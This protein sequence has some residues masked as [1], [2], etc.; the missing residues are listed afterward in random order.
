MATVPVLPSFEEQ[1]RHASALMIAIDIYPKMMKEMLYNKYKSPSSVIVVYQL[2][3]NVID[4]ENDPLVKQL[5]A[6]EKSIVKSINMDGFAKCDI[7]LLYRLIRYFKLLPAPSRGWGAKPSIKEIREG[8]DVER[9]KRYRNDLVHRPKG[10]LSESE[11]TDIF[12][13]SINIAKRLDS[14]SP[15]HDF[16][17]K[18][19]ATKYVTQEKYVTA[20]EQCAENRGLL[21]QAQVNLLYGQDIVIKLGH[22][23][24]NNSSGTNSTRY[25]I[26]TR[27]ANMDVPA[28]IKRLDEIK[29]K[30]NDGSSEVKLLGGEIGSL[31]LDITI[32]NASFSTKKIL[33]DVLDLFLQQLFLHADIHQTPGKV[34][35]A[36]LTEN[37]ND[38]FSSGSDQGEYDFL[39]EKRSSVLKLDVDI[40]N[41]AFRDKNVLHEEISRFIDDVTGARDDDDATM[42]NGSPRDVMI[43][44]TQEKQV[45]TIDCKIVDLGHKRTYNTCQFYIRSI[46]RHWKYLKENLDV[47][48]ISN[49]LSMSKFIKC[50][51]FEHV[52]ENPRREQ[53]ENILD[54]VIRTIQ[55]SED[56]RTFLRIVENHQKDV[57]D[58]IREPFIYTE[59]ENPTSCKDAKKDEQRILLNKEML[60]ME[61]T[62]T[63]VD[64]ILDDFMEADVFDV[65]DLDDIKRPGKS[66]KTSVFIERLLQKMQKNAYL[67]L[68]KTLERIKDPSICRRILGDLEATP[69]LPHETEDGKITDLRIPNTMIVRSHRS[70]LIDEIDPLLMIDECVQKNIY[71]D[72]EGLERITDRK[73][74]ARKFLDDLQEHDKCTS[75]EK[76]LLNVFETKAMHCLSKKLAFSQ[77][78]LN[79]KDTE[80]LRQNIVRYRKEIAESVDIDE[81]KDMFIDRNIFKESLFQAIAERY[82]DKRQKRVISLLT[83]ILPAGWY[84]WITLIDVL[85][86][87]TFS[88]LAHTL[89]NKGEDNQ[90]LAKS[91]PLMFQ[92]DTSDRIEDAETSS[93]SDKK[94]K[95]EDADKSYK[96][97]ESRIQELILNVETKRLEVETARLNIERRKLE[98]KERQFAE[99]ARDSS[100][101]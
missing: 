42:Q 92:K 87:R 79:Y 58:K 31:I 89:L 71:I 81:M 24:E 61:L 54:K 60:E 34:L 93:T 20:L 18:V 26:Y 48:S 44:S 27:D 76:D 10:G 36:V 47:V 68:Q 53:A 30:L 96:S 46:T 4:D 91:I 75:L 8:D 15:T 39:C 32:S 2:I 59:E 77:T 84:A 69:I 17:S 51:N 11:K 9:M 98:L 43:V 22:Q 99:L 100:S 83:Q 5:T 73:S 66:S 65:H 16:E 7:S 13:E 21:K 88:S 70:F 45:A 37:D 33:H 52:C 78:L 85:Y 49:E 38:A 86:W 95:T 62:S 82:P 29:Q 64:E 41:C 55:R 57:A 3:Q 72:Q 35:D 40:H 90:W 97:N 28:V 19:R 14:R 67:H 80:A 50:I 101:F 23:E 12:T 1:E 74:R 6:L 63:D 94:D 25:S 56:F